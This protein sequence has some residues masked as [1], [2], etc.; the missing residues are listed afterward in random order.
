MKDPYNNHAQ[1]YNYISQPVKMCSS[2]CV[3]VLFEAQ[4]REF[5]RL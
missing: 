2:L 1:F 3:C 4:K 5:V